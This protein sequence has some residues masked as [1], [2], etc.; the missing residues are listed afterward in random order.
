LAELVV[1]TLVVRNFKVEGVTETGK[2]PVPAKL[3]DCGLLL[4]LSVMVKA[5]DLTPVC[6]GAKATLT[7]QEAFTLRT[8][9]QVEATTLKSVELVPVSTQELRVTARPVLLV[10]VT[11]LAEL[12]L[13]RDCLAKDSEVGRAHV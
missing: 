8:P 10:M 3:T 6:C 7:V 4:E 5:A 9:P 13:P 11:F 2:I 12:V 1:P